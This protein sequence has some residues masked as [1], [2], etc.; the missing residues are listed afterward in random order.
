MLRF[1]KLATPAATGTVVVPDNVPAPGFV[2]IA[3]TMLPTKAVA[4]LPWASSAATCTG[5]AI[6]AP[7]NAVV[8]CAVKASCVA[9]PGVTSKPLLVAAVRPVVLACNV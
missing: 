4:T 1:E 9:V 5:G 6:C 2:P 3:M 7:V 8:G